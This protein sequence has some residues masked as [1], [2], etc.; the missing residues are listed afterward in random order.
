MRDD[1]STPTD[2]LDFTRRFAEPVE[3]P[4]RAP[5][6]NDEIDP[7]LG[8]TAAELR[9]LDAFSY[10]LALEAAEDPRPPTPEEQQSIDSLRER[11]EQLQ[12]MSPEE[13][14]AERQRI[15]AMERSLGMR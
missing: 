12:R 6:V 10:E 13:V 4:R 1:W 11:F 2:E 7:V 3:P 5:A 8:V 14:E 9:I 15:L